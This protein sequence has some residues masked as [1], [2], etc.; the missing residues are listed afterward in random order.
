MSPFA[1]L[2]PAL[3]SIILINVTIGLYINHAKRREAM[4]K[5]GVLIC[6]YDERL[7]NEGIPIVKKPTNVIRPLDRKT[8]LAHLR[9]M[10]C[11]MG[12]SW[13]FP[14]STAG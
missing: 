3:L 4:D 5:I 6:L 1:I 14:S 9:W 8:N 12:T 11:E 2:F 7:K 13:T 10:M